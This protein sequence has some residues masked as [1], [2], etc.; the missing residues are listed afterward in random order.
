M[1][2]GEVK[3]AQGFIH[4]LAWR[5]ELRNE[6]NIVNPLLFLNASIIPILK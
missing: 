4:G 5:V 6:N 1:T 3:T 2:I